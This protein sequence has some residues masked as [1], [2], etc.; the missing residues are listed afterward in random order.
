MC[1]R[2]WKSRVHSVESCVGE[3][4]TRLF[5]EHRPLSQL[6]VYG[7]SKEGENES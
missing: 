3:W 7:A 5:E 4:R 1:H 6:Y 2:H